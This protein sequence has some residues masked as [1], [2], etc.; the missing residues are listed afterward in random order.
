MR[1][2]LLPLIIL[3]DRVRS[4]DRFIFNTKLYS[5]SWTNILPIVFPIKNTLNGPFNWEK[6][7]KKFNLRSISRMKS[8][9]K[10][11]AVKCKCCRLSEREREYKKSQRLEGNRRDG[12]EKWT[13]RV[14]EQ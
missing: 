1:D 4:I 11:I 14:T 10:I 3:H 12:I 2:D 6:I 7:V 13:E 5:Y 8:N 9:R